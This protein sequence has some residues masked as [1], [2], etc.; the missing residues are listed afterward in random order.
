L[1][2][3]I[4]YT[5]KRNSN[6]TLHLLCFSLAFSI[7]YGDP[8][9]GQDLHSRMKVLLR[10]EVKTDSEFNLNDPGTMSKLLEEVREV[11]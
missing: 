5:E 2:D 11:E 1:T 7:T 3:L 6:L 9:P 8:D 10:F 4:Y